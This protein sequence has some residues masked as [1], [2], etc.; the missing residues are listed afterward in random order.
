MRQRRADFLFDTRAQEARSIKV[1]TDLEQLT[2]SLSLSLTLSLSLSL[3]LTLT[4]ALTLALTLA[5]LLTR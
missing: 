5:L 4:P 1:S 2:L 3:T